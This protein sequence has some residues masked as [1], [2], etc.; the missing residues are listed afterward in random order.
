M[1][2]AIWYDLLLTFVCVGLTLYQ[3][4]RKTKPTDITPA[5]REKMK[6][7]YNDCYKAVLNCEDDNGRRRCD[8]FKE[9][10]DKKVKLSL[11]QASTCGLI[12]LALAVSRLLR[13]HPTADRD[14]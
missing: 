9:L 12:R 13:G 8:L 11:H 4:R 6:K 5:I 3:K 14:G 10:P 7:A 1:T 2:T